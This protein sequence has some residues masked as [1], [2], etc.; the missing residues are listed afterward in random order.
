MNHHHCCPC[1]H[2]IGAPWFSYKGNGLGCF[3]LHLSAALWYQQTTS[4]TKK[5]LLLLIQK[6]G[7]IIKEF[8]VPDGYST[9]LDMTIMSCPLISLSED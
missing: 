3:S 4:S 8:R 9:L 7:R 5:W 2:F 6:F 1:F